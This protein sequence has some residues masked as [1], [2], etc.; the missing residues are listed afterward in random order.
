MVISGQ[1]SVSAAATVNAATVFSVSGTSLSANSSQ[2]TTPVVAG[3][4]SVTT[5]NTGSINLLED[6]SSS[7][8]KD[9]NTGG[10][11]ASSVIMVMNQTS[12]D[13]LDAF[14]SMRFV[15]APVS[16]GEQL[17]SFATGKAK[18]EEID[19]GTIGGSGEDLVGENKLGSS[20]FDVAEDKLTETAKLDDA[21]RVLKNQYAN[22][23]DKGSISGVQEFYWDSRILN[24]AV[25]SETNAAAIT[26]TGWSPALHI[27]HADIS[28]TDICSASK[29]F[30]FELPTPGAK[31]DPADGVYLTQITNTNPTMNSDGNSCGAGAGVSNFFAKRDNAQSKNIYMNFGGGEPFKSP[32]PAGTWKVKVD[33]ETVAKFDLAVSYPLIPDSSDQTKLVPRVYIPAL[34]VR[35]LAFPSD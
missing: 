20:Q 15:G 19:L 10:N 8:D 26:F 14:E 30:V 4:L 29:S 16:G 21:M 11:A 22:T 7:G 17:L 34:K 9:G 12:T 27:D 32:I 28:F 35:G 13:L 33:N 31:R 1:L 2:P 25:N 18:T 24:D 3:S 6:N 23:T 5:G